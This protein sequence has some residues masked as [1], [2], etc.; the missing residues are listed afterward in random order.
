MINART[1]AN[2]RGFSVSETTTTAKGQYNDLVRVTLEENDVYHTLTAT[3]FGGEDPRVVGIDNFQI[4]LRLEGELL[5]YQ[6]QDIPGMLASV[7]GALASREINIGAL[8]LG[9]S[10]KGERALTVLQVDRALDEDDLAAIQGIDGVEN[11][12]VCSLSRF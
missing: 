11:V 1:Y 9:R 2:E 7:S 5:V 4:E 10:S 6:N 8:S 3:L 12:H